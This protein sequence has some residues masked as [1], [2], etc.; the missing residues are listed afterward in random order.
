M[1]A[2]TIA[3]TTSPVDMRVV[4]APVSFGLGDLVVSL[5][6][7]QALVAR[8][9][10]GDEVWLLARAPSQAGL[11]ERVEGLGG[12]VHEHDHTP[13]PG[14]R[15]VDLRDHPLQRDHWW[16][17]PEFAAAFGH[18]GIN[19]ILERICAD[20][21]IDADFSQP[22]PLA[23]RHRP[24]LERTVLL[25]HETDGPEKRWPVERWRLVAA[26]LRAAGYD[27]AQ[28]VREEPTDD[29]LG[30]PACVAPTPGDAVDVLTACRGVIGVDTGLTHIA[31]QQGRPTVVICRR[32]SVYVRPWAHCRA[33]RGDHCTDECVAAEAAYAYN[34]R[35]SLR[36][37][38]PPPRR[39]PS[40]AMCLAG[41][42]PSDAVG[43][44]MEVL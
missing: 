24:G 43:L 1:Q 29:A 15:L 31:V 38:A 39:C 17:S 18:L 21:S 7:I 40:D 19:D 3:R 8:A 14:Q 20:F 23:S 36:S 11:A 10:Q 22:R 27:V 25:V 34:D 32:S 6:A 2:S 35:V 13:D 30:L 33:L 26:S 12:V 9:R 16:G 44:L 28:V 5:P 41:T 37:F 42:A 4:V